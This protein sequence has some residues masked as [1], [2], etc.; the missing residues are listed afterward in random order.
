MQYSGGI[1]VLSA[2]LAAV[3]TAAR[4]EKPGSMDAMRWHHRVVLMSSPDAGDPNLAAQRRILD[5]WKAGAADRDIV[6]VQVG[7]AQAQGTTDSANALR[8]R[9]ELPAS[10]FQVLLIGKDGHVALRSAQPISAA[11]LAGT[12]DAMPMRKA[13]QR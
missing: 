1:V 12:I 2:V 3:P 13:G 5:D 6:L 11:T 9:Y 8:K 4:A 7:A 10:G